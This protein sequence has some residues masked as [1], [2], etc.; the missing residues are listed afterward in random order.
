MDT[1]RRS[2]RADAGAVVTRRAQEPWAPE[3]LAEVRAR[4]PYRQCS[5]CGESIGAARLTL[6]PEA[7]T[8]AWCAAAARG[9]AT[10]STGWST[11]TPDGATRGGSD[12]ARRLAA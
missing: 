8:C 1:P 11:A 9:P 12:P 3:F 7:R 5:V 2:D 4:V 6:W 10:T